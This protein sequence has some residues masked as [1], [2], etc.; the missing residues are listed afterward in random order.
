MFR[1]MVIVLGPE[2]KEKTGKGDW[3]N[4]AKNPPTTKSVFSL[5]H[6]DEKL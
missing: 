6:K 5:K 1:A 2:R 3:N 4:P